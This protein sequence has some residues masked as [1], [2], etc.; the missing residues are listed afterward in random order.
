MKSTAQSFTQPQSVLIL[1]EPGTGKT[2]LASQF[3]QPFI[4]DCDVNIAGPVKWLK[5]NKRR[6]EFFYGNPT[7]NDAGTLVPREEQFGRAC[8][9]LEEAA[10]SPDVSTIIIDSLTT[11][12][13]IVLTEVLRQQKRTLGTLQVKDLKT[14]TLDEPMQIQDWGGFFGLMKRT[15]F[16]LKASGKTLVITGHIKTDKD[17]LTKILKQFIYCPGTMSDVIAGFFSEVWLLKRETKI[18]AGAKQESRFLMTFPDG[19]AT[20]ALGLKSS[21]GLKSGEAINLDKIIE[22]LNQP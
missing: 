20:E 2:T 3:K 4:L 18:V 14:R 9:L 19:S 1:G 12:S 17:E 22:L 11:F 10:A 15:I 13:D 5:D 16:G 7:V 6:S 8:A 21:V